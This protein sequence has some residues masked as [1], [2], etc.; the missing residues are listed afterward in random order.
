MSV[1]LI[2]FV[3][4]DLLSAEQTIL[5]SLVISFIK[6]VLSFPSVMY[7][8]LFLDEVVVAKLRGVGPEWEG[9][10]HASEEGVI[11]IVLEFLLKDLIGELF[12]VVFLHI[13]MLEVGQEMLI[14]NMADLESL[15]F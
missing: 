8:Y 13:E 7:L 10:L 6:S 12:A 11:L 15:P 14:L 1:I 3:V 4:D 5:Q 2:I 9:Y